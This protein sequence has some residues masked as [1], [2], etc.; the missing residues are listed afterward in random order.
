MPRADR[1]SAPKREMN[2][3]SLGIAIAKTT[4]KKN[5]DVLKLKKRYYSEIFQDAIFETYLLFLLFLLIFY[6]FYYLNT[7][8]FVVL[9][10]AEK[11]FLLRKFISIFFFINLRNILYQP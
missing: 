9:Y 7:N 4:E 5:K 10:I 8:I 11:L 2:K 1:Q 3:P 6:F